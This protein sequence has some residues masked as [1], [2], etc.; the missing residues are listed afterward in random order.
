MR[1]IAS[2]GQLWAAY[3]RWAVVTVPFILLL[4][5]TSAR[6]APAGDQNPWFMRLVKPEI[7]PPNW[8]FP[9]AWSVLYVLLG[10]ALAMIINARGS[11]LRGPALVVFAVQMAVNL[12]WSPV[13]FGMHQV[14]PALIIIGVL[15][16][17]A[18]ITTILFAR[19]RLGAAILLLPYLAWI[20]FAGYLLFLINE[21]NPNAASLVPSRSADQIQI[22]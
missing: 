6:L 9:V 15:F 5:F 14:V 2:R 22:R 12:A 1:E 13:F 21:L 3:L 20:G 18:L 11:T 8:A 10:L 19:I 17:L 7:M 16:V 4:G